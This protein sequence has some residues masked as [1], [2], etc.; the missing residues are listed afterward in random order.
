MGGPCS[1]CIRAVASFS[2]PR[3]VI[4]HHYRSHQSH[5]TYNHTASMRCF[6]KFLRHAQFSK[7]PHTRRVI[8]LISWWG[9]H[10]A[11]RLSVLPQSRQDPI[12][13][14]MGR[15]RHPSAVHYL[16]AAHLSDKEITS[17]CL[18]PSSY[19]LRAFSF[20]HGAT[21]WV[22]AAR[23]AVSLLLCHSAAGLLG[24]GL[25]AATQQIKCWS[26]VFF[27]KLSRC[28]QA[29]GCNPSPDHGLLMNLS[30]PSKT[31]NHCTA[32]HALN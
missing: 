25:L 13:R 11:E 9:N 24:M 23:F 26:A 19:I 3:T 5:L 31:L 8:T 21:P 10:S 20:N 22:F 1:S 27:H 2:F 14:V 17:L 7:L 30:A 32:H 15:L 16:F 6:T 12:A 18:G 29:D 4:R 28:C